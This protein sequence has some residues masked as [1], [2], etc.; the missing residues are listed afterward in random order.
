MNEELNF[1]NIIIR[2]HGRK[3]TNSQRVVDM[4]MH[5]GEKENKKTM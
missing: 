3:A 4:I 5:C 2:K 1:K